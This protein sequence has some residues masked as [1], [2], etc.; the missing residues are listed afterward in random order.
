MWNSGVA[1]RDISPRYACA[2]RAPAARAARAAARKTHV[3]P[4][5]SLYL[6]MKTH[7]L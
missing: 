6:M 2:C 1:L 4:Y 3:A 5:F 7:F